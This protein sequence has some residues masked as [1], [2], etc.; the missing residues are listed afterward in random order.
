MEPQIQQTSDLEALRCHQG[1]SYTAQ[2]RV[3][4]ARTEPALFTDAAQVLVQ[5]PRRAV[6]IGMGPWDHGMVRLVRSHVKATL[7][8]DLKGL[9]FFD[10][11]CSHFDNLTPRLS[12]ICLLCLVSYFLG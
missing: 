9:M 5:P 2:T 10:V 7:G 1:T 3:L 11:F 6:G 4:T 8:K 12:A